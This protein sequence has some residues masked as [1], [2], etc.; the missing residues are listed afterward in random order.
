M[1]ELSSELR[2]LFIVASAA[3]FGFGLANLGK[4]SLDKGNAFGDGWLGEMQLC[5]DL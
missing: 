1:P 5:L 3:A 2:C 4:M